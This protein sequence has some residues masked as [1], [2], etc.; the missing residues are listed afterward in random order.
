M[1]SL[2]PVPD[3]RTSDLMVGYYKRLM[4]GDGRGDALRQV[5]LRMLAGQPHAHPYYW[6]GFVLVGDRD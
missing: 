2:W 6:A 4:N 1:M 5:Q 3:R